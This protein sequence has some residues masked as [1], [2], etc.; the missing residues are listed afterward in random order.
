MPTSISPHP[1]VA[2]LPSLP[3]SPSFLDAVFSHPRPWSV[4]T[5]DIDLQGLRRFSTESAASLFKGKGKQAMEVEDEEDEVDTQHDG[6]THEAYPP[7]TDDVA[8]TRRVEETLKRWEFAERQR[9]KTVRESVH[10]T[11]GLSLLSSVT[12]TAN[13]VISGKNSIGTSAGP[14]NA[15]TFKSYETVNVAREGYAV[16]LDDIDH[17]R[18]D[19]AV[20][21]PSA[22]LF[23]RKASSDTGRGSAS[24]SGTSENPFVHPSERTRTQTPTPA[25]TPMIP[26]CSPPSPSPFGDTCAYAQQAVQGDLTTRISAE[27][28]THARERSLGNRASPVLPPRPLGLFPPPHATQPQPTSQPVL[29]SPQPRRQDPEE[30]QEVRWWHDW[31]CGCGEN[32]DRGG[33]NQAGRTNPFE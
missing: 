20:H 14:G 3:P 4:S 19:I 17:T 25:P 10:H 5:Q 28:K 12:R 27:S 13:L 23:D 7:T 30:R 26:P 15:R 21:S 2:I 29:R 31:L 18:Q 11:S 16:P 22:S 8:E 6:S 9:R 32:P 1:E 24:G 33:D